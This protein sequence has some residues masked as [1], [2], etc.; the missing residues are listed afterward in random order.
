[1][2]R[3]AMVL[4]ALMVATLAMAGAAAAAPVSAPAVNL[5]LG[6]PTTASN[7]LPDGQSSLAVDGDPNTAWNSGHYPT[8]WIEVDLG[9]AYAIGEMNLAITQLPDGF[10]VHRVYAKSAADGIYALLHEF[11]G[12][13]TASQVLTHNFAPAAQDVRFFRV[14]TIVSPSWVAWHEIEIC[15]TTCPETLTLTSSMTLTEDHYGNILIHS[16]NVTLDCAGHTIHGPGVQGINGG[17]DIVLSNG[18]TVKNCTISQFAF[19][20]GIFAAVGSNLRL[21]NNTLVGNAANGVHVDRMVDGVLIGNRSDS[22]AGYGIALTDSR[23]MEVVENLVERN[24]ASGI[25]L[26]EASNGNTVKANQSEANSNGFVAAG[27]VTANAFV[28]NLAKANRQ[29]GFIL[30]EGASGNTLTNNTAKANGEN[31]F[32]VFAS[33]G[34]TLKANQAEANSNGFVVAGAATANAFVDNRAKAN[35]ESGFILVEA[36]SDNTL[37]DNL[38]QA[39]GGNGFTV[40]ASNGNTFRTNAASD[41]GA[42]G[43]WLQTVERSE[44]AGN[45]VQH[46]RRS[47]IVL[48]ETTRSRVIGNLVSEN[49]N[50]GLEVQSSNG[51]ELIGNDVRSHPSDGIAIFFSSNNVVVDNRSIGN[52]WG[53]G[54][55]SSNLHLLAGNQVT[56]SREHGILLLDDSTGNRVERNHVVQSGLV[57]FLVGGGDGNTL[58]D[59]IANQNGDEGFVLT[60]GSTGNTL[61]SNGSMTNRVGFSVQVG[62]TGNTLGTNVAHANAAIDAEDQNVAGSNTWLKNN[63]GA[64]A[65]IN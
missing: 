55:Y 3:A 50:Y 7:A 21:Q 12:F 20:N 43:I 63:F 45:Q 64:T 36:A 6:R 51:N 4:S 29:T 10:T 13:T 44:L 33:N 39:N 60:P 41:N 27:A 23:R 61:T 14:E 40:D 2:R 59:N 46:N 54:L 52:V 22:N 18:V 28:D 31:G 58:T 47:G 19:A 53:I 32:T 35:R 25:A 34:N 9:A 8:Q 1:M 42:D 26:L 15:P 17:V 11:A 57:G 5:A 62:A 48:V 24:G 30:V 16:D 49:G 56:N 38:A 65:G 37:T